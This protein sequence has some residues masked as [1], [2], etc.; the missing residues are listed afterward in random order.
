M[1]EEEGPP[2]SS[3]VSEVVAPFEAV[4]VV[5]LTRRRLGA[6]TS[7]CGL[8]TGTSSGS[9]GSI[10][11]VLRLVWSMKNCLPL[12]SIFD[13]HPVL[14]RGEERVQKSVEKLQNY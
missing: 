8:T 11:V 3:V 14:R 13:S 12:L 4:V 2:L 9:R 5:F 10:N 1:G 7:L 6:N